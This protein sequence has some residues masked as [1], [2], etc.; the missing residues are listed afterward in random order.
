MST[1]LGVA[2]APFML[3]LFLVIAYPFKRL[4]ID[5]MKD[6]KLKRLLLLRLSK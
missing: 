3:L 5:K 6:G 4:V 1:F 2:I